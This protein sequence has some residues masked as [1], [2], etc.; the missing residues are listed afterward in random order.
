LF[1]GGSVTRITLLSNPEGRFE[2][3]NNNL[4]DDPKG[5]DDLQKKRGRPDL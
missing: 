1:S 3:L 5:K 2:E 4:E